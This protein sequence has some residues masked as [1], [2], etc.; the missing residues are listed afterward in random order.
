MC[1]KGAI[2][3]PLAGDFMALSGVILAFFAI[4]TSFLFIFSLF[5]G[6]L[7]WRAFCF[8]QGVRVKLQLIKRKVIK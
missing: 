1:Q 6:V 5:S 7:L 2:S 4:V 8:K 3:V